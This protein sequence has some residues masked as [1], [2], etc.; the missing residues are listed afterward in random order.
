[1]S[2]YTNGWREGT[3]GIPTDECTKRFHYQAKVYETGS[4]FGIDGGRISKLWVEMDGF[5]VINYDRGWD[6]EPDENDEAIMTAY[7]IILQEHN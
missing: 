4:E 6:V 7:R 5:T 3:I 2:A 1:M